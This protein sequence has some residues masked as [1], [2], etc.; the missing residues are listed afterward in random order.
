VGSGGLV[1]FVAPGPL[2]A[3]LH[4]RFAGATAPLSD[5]LYATCALPVYFPPQNIDGQRLADGGLRAVLPLALAHGIPADLVLAVNVGPG[6]GE[7][8]PLV[9]HAADV[10]SL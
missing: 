6:F 5:V 8:L 9:R 10:R 4:A 1:V 2:A 3:V 7:T